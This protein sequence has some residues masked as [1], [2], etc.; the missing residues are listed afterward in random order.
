[1]DASA[2]VATRRSAR[3]AAQT[4]ENKKSS[5]P[6]ER[7][8]RVNN[9]RAATGPSEEPCCQV[10]KASSAI[11]DADNETTRGDPLALFAQRLFVLAA[12]VKQASGSLAPADAYGLRLSRVR[13]L[14]SA[15][16]AASQ[17]TI[18]PTLSLRDPRCDCAELERLQTQHKDAVNSSEVV[19][20]VVTLLK[21]LQAAAG[22]VSDWAREE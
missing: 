5:E 11:N 21:N 14:E 8:T 2:G 20:D 7:P 13:L 19:R 17:V 12:T 15:E 22:C 16:D 10:A 1:M 3:R 6:S 9:R 18:D 4:A